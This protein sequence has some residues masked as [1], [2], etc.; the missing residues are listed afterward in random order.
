MNTIL[1]Q[2]ALSDHSEQEDG[3]MDDDDEVEED[4]EDEDEDGVVPKGKLLH[5]RLRMVGLGP[6]DSLDD[7]FHENIIYRGLFRKK[8]VSLEDTSTA[9]PDLAVFPRDQ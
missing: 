7:E 1:F 5:P 8:S 9:D 2:C 6:S 3:I 4:D